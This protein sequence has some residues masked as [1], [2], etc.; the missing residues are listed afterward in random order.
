MVLGKFLADSIY[1]NVLPSTW[2]FKCKQ[3]PSGDIRKLDSV[4]AGIEGFFGEVTQNV[5]IPRNEL[6]SIHKIVINILEIAF[7]IHFGVNH[8]D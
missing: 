2:A 7:H 4:C 1:L 6:G 8:F 3:C 5:I